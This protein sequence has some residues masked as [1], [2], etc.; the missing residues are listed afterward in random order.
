MCSESF[1]RNDRFNVVYK[2]DDFIFPFEP[3]QTMSH[4]FS[5]F[6]KRADIRF[7]EFVDHV[8]ICS[9]KRHRMLMNPAE[10]LYEMSA[11]QRLRSLYVAILYVLLSFPIQI[12][13]HPAVRSEEHTSELQSPCNLVCRL[14]LD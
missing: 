14:L 5:Q 13:C 9:Q 3:K 10:V 12:P 4:G 1:E 6:N 11:V 7:D 8:Q 2:W